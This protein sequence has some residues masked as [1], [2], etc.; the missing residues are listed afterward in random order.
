MNNKIM[1]KQYEDERIN[2]ELANMFKMAVKDEEYQDRFEIGEDFNILINNI[3]KTLDYVKSGYIGELRLNSNIWEI[4]HQA[5]VRILR[6]FNLKFIGERTTKYG[7]YE[8]IVPINKVGV[9]KEKVFSR[10][11]DYGWHLENWQDVYEI[12]CDF[13]EG[14]YDYFVDH[15]IDTEINLNDIDQQSLY[16]MTAFMSDFLRAFDEIDMEMSNNEREIN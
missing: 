11:E 12:H 3:D 16:D 5:M 1:L 13:M 15:D 7:E 2:K 4:C 6:L 14:L 8:L 9:I 10:M